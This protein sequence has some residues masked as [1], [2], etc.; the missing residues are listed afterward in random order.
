MLDCMD[1]TRNGHEDW[2]V[3]GQQ[4]VFSA[5]VERFTWEGQWTVSNLRDKNLIVARATD[6]IFIKVYNARETPCNTLE[7]HVRR[8]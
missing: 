5:Y 4:C 2:C 7:A 1:A 3:L 8:I 6:D